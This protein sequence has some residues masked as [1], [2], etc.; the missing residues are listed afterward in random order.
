LETGKWKMETGKSKLETGRSK[1]ANRKSAIGNPTPA[2]FLLA[3]PALALR[4][5]KSA[6]E[7]WQCHL[8]PPA[9]HTPIRPI[10]P[11]G[12]ERNG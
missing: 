7:N 9:D 2:Y 8:L 10:I 4:N 3:T 1:I 12:E 6:I 11:A 5:R